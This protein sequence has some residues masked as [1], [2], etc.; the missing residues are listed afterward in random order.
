METI[1]E[2]LKK[3]NLHRVQKKDTKDYL[4]NMKI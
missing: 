3:M 2:I 4:K 1:E